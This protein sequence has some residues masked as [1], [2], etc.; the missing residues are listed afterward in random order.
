MDY[1]LPSMKGFEVIAETRR[2]PPARPWLMLMSGGADLEKVEM[3][4]KAGVDDFPK[5]VNEI[6]LLV[7]LRTAGAPHLYHE[8]QERWSRPITPRTIASPVCS[9]A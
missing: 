6:D 5:P 1:E 2:R 3:A 9:I 4:N 7:R 8:L